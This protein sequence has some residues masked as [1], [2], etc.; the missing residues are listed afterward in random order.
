MKKA[1]K[2]WSRKHRMW[3]DRDDRTPA[4]K[5]RHEKIAKDLDRD[6]KR[7]Q[8][9]LR[10]EAE[11]VIL[12][13]AKCFASSED[14]SW[15]ERVDGDDK[16]SHCFNCG[17]GNCAVRIPRWAVKSIREQASWVG[18][19]YYPHEEDKEIHNEVQAL[20]KLVK[21]FPGRTAERC[22]KGWWVSQ[23]IP[24]DRSRSHMMFVSLAKAKT[25]AE[26]IERSREI[27]RYVPAEAMEK[28][29]KKP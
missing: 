15:G 11:R 18:K 22:E 28:P 25:A 10:M 21:K 9:K 3:V 5:A 24:C 13:C 6:Q 19:R 2:V 29:K 16:G 17:A 12:F 23:E 26:A 20:R 8:E 7:V 14:G 1:G 27:L 4:E